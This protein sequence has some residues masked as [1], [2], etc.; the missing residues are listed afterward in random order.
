MWDTL[1][2]IKNKL[3]L[4]DIGQ[5]T[6]FFQ[7]DHVLTLFHSFIFLKCEGKV[8]HFLKMYGNSLKV[9]ESMMSFIGI[10]RS[11]SKKNNLNCS[12]NIENT[13]YCK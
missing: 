13:Y 10:Y 3:I 11:S 1:I 8:S 7:F 6:I 2:C 9:L 4:S 12:N 5:G